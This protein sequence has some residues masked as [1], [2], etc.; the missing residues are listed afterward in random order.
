ME[1]LTD[2]WPFVLGQQ[3]AIFRVAGLAIIGLIGLNVYSA[4]RQR[5]PIRDVIAALFSEVGAASK[6]EKWVRL[7]LIGWLLVGFLVLLLDIQVNGLQ[8]IDQNWAKK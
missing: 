7:A 5:L 3:H 1:W 2:I 6:A 8:I 4:L